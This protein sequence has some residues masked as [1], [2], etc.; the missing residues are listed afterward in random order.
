MFFG[1]ISVAT[2]ARVRPVH[3]QF[4]LG[5]INE[6]RNGP[7]G[8]IGFEERIISMAIEAVAVL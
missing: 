6:K 4:Q 5:L 7:A 3:R 1:D 8:G 2:D